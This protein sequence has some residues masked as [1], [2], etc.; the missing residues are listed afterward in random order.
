MPK[1][2][3]LHR[4]SGLYARFQVPADL[5]Q[6][7]GCIYLVRPLRARADYARLVSAQMAVALSQVFDAWRGGLVNDDELKAFT[8][9]LN[10]LNGGK[11]RDYK[12]R[13]GDMEIE[14]VD[15]ADHR[16]ALEMAGLLARSRTATTAPPPIKSLT[17]GKAVA[18]HLADLEREKLDGRT[19]DDSRHS[20]RLFTAIVGE[21]REVSSLT[22]DDMRAF[23]DGVRW[24][25]KNA[26]KRPPYRDMAVLEVIALAKSK[27]EPPPKARTIQKHIQRLSVLLNLLLKAKFIAENPLHGM[28]GIP[29]AESDDGGRPFTDAELATIF[30]PARFAEWAKKYPHRW[31][32]TMLGLYSGAR[33]TEIAQLQ[34]ADIE[35]VDGIWGFCVRR[36]VELRQKV[37]NQ[38]SFRFIPIAKPVLEAGFLTYLG[39]A[40]K[41]GHTRLFPNLP[42]STGL[43]FGRQLSRQFS[44]YIKDKCGIADAGLGFHGFRHTIASELDRRGATLPEISA[45]T[46]H[47][48]DGQAPVLFDYYIRKTLPDRVATLAKFKPPVNL[49]TYSRDQFRR[50]FRSAP[51]NL[52][53]IKPRK[54]SPVGRS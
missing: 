16:R 22:Q 20:L 32:G 3:I 2:L 4:P 48:V 8:S 18:D 42:N 39:E 14:A 17:V 35:Q 10:A 36:R 27:N 28:R 19:V 54:S 24:W 25:P 38:S 13:I 9:G 7:V 33:V 30:E 31:F 12:I 46:G 43:G 44:D 6:A 11:V 52:A 47:T 37:K 29:Q 15:E 34:I 50:A 1:P 49:P 21:G 23:L 40:K 51:I 41:A 26:S 45:I 5:R 53:P